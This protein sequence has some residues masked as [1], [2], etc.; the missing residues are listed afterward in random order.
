M[1]TI[2]K[3]YLKYNTYKKKHENIHKYRIKYKISK[4][5]NT[6]KPSHIFKTYINKTTTYKIKG[7]INRIETYIT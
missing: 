1:N 3:K 2:K 5:E 4:I 6:G 7:K